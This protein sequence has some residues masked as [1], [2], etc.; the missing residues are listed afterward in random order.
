MTSFCRTFAEEKFSQSKIQNLKSK[1]VLDEQNKTPSVSQGC[2]QGA[3]TIPIS[4]E[5]D[6]PSG[7]FSKNTIEKLRQFPGNQILIGAGL[8]GN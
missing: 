1:I 2:N 5:N 7:H 6:L 4:Y 3:S 8:A